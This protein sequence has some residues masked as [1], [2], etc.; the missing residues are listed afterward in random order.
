MRTRLQSQTSPLKR[1]CPFGKKTV[2]IGPVDAFFEMVPP[3]VAQ[4]IAAL[5]AAWIAAV[6][7]LTPSQAA[8]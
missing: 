3:A 1:V 2:A 8:P 4:S 5:I 7:S 6:S